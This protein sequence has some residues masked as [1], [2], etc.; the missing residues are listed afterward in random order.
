MTSYPN[1]ISTGDLADPAYI[2]DLVTDLASHKASSL[3]H[4]SLPKYRVGSDFEYASVQ[5]ALDAMTAAGGCVEIDA[6]TLQNLSA[7]I[8]VSK[9]K[10]WIKGQG[11]LNTVLQGKGISIGAD[12]S[13]IRISDLCILGNDINNDVGIQQ[14]PTGDNVA[15][16][17]FDH[18]HLT[19]LNKGIELG[20]SGGVLSVTD[21]RIHDVFCEDNNMD[22]DL[23]YNKYT[24]YI[25]NCHFYGAKW[26]PIR[27]GT[28]MWVTMDQFTISTS[29]DGPLISLSQPFGGVIQNGWLENNK[30]TGDVTPRDISISGVMA[31]SMAFKSL[32][33]NQSRAKDMVLIENNA[34]CSFEECW[35][36]G[37]SG[38]Y[39]LAIAA[40]G[41]MAYMQKCRRYPLA[42]VTLWRKEAGTVV[43]V[44]RQEDDGIDLRGGDG[45]YL[46]VGVIASLP[47]ASAAYRGMVI[48]TEGTPD[49]IF[50]CLK[51]S[52]GSYSWVQV[53]A[54]A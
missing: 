32:K 25:R 37:P 4:K 2:N 16:A 51:N 46:G 54:G 20:A 22:L 3:L 29:L 12:V 17:E 36:S 15:I 27:F 28:E 53:G 35:F 44:G 30:T 31:G 5:A 21:T 48:R 42:D 10:V 19:N 14:I 6:E 1:V 7:P 50:C 33:I 49:K 8:T 18:L 34:N 13:R 39:G 52:D 11:F 40:S 43:E 38:S 9:S 45:V 41:G 26:L 23:L 24:T 47:S